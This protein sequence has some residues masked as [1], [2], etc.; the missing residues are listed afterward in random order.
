IEKKSDKETLYKGS[1]WTLF[2]GIVNLGSNH[3][4]DKLTSGLSENQVLTDLEVRDHISLPGALLW[5]VTGGIISHHDMDVRGRIATIKEP[6]K[7]RLPPRVAVRDPVTAAP[8]R[9]FERDLYAD[10]VIDRPFGEVVGDFNR[11]AS[12]AGLLTLAD[13][14]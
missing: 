2:W 13:I 14:D 6:D 11:A 9:D 10:A 4:E 1:D 12:R 3:P 5:I 7:D 8:A